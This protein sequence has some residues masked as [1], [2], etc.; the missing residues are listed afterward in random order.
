MRTWGGAVGIEPHQDLVDGGTVTPPQF[1]LYGLDGHWLIEGR[2]VEPDIEVANL[3][4]DV[5]AGADTQLEAA[6]QHLLETLAHR[7]PALGDPAGAR[8]S[9]QEQAGRRGAAVAAI[10]G[11]ERGAASWPPL[12]RCTAR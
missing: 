1:G 3:P 5:V 7:G 10:R 9:R 4:A 8:L 11:I 2:G 6:V 12:V